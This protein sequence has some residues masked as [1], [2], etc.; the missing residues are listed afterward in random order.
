VTKGKAT[1]EAALVLA[2]GKE[3]G[4]KE[5]LKKNSNRD[6]YAATFQGKEKRGEKKPSHPQPQLKRQGRFRAKKVDH[7]WQRF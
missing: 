4:E 5:N 6:C 3:E 7:T 1:S 2:F